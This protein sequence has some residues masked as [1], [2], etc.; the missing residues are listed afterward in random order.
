LL[1]LCPSQGFASRASFC[2]VAIP[3]FLAQAADQRDRD[4]DCDAGGDPE[5]DVSRGRAESGTHGSA[6]RDR[7]AQRSCVMYFVLHKVLPCGQKAINPG[8]W[9]PVT[10]N[11]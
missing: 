11:R 7:Q 3:F 10:T 5:A 1:V 6:E 4:V 8:D 9:S 2:L